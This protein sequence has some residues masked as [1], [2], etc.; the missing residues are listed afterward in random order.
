M[1]GH[2]YDDIVLLLHWFLLQIKA[3]AILTYPASKAYFYLLDEEK[4]GRLCLN[5]VKPLKS[6]KLRLLDWSIL[7]F[8]DKLVF[9]ERA[10][11]Y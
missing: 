9:R 8:I 5:C 6:P 7:F 1:I 2:L 4:K 3:F 11:V 10:Y